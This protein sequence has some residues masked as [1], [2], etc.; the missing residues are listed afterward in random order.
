MKR[1]RRGG[2]AGGLALTAGNM[3]RR[4]PIGAEP[5]MPRAAPARTL[6]AALVKPDDAPRRL[7]D[8]DDSFNLPSALVVAN[9]NPRDNGKGLPWT[10]ACHSTPDFSPSQATLSA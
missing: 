2:S 3:P 7:G 5:P 6:T 1:R 8:V 10:S 9:D 4:V